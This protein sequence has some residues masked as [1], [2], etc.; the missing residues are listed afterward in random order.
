MM[1]RIIYSDQYS[2]Q[3]A[4]RIRIIEPLQ[5]LDQKETFQCTPLSQISREYLVNGRIQPDNP[6]F[7]DADI[8]YL[9]ITDANHTNIDKMGPIIDY[10][11]KNGKPVVTNLDDL[12]F[13]IPKNV[14]IKQELETSMP[15]FKELVRISRLVLVTGKQL[16]EVSAQINPNVIAI[17]NMIDPKMYPSRPD[18]NEKIHIGW[19][20]LPTHF[21][22]F[23]ITLPAIKELLRNYPDKV[24]FTIFG[25]FISDMK[26]VIT[27]A[28]NLKIGT[29]ELKK[30]F[31]SG[32]FLSDAIRMAQALEDI[33]FR[34][35][36]LV[37]Y[38][39]FPKML[40]KLDFDIG[41]CPLRDNLFNRCK[42]AIKF[43]QYAAVNTVSVASKMYPYSAECNY[44]VENNPEAW[45]RHIEALI[46]DK[47][48]RE[49]LLQE[50]RS[51]IFSN[52]N[53]NSGISIYETIFKK[54]AS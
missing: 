29:Q 30:H 2:N 54:L 39:N 46:L 14:T 10:F 36:P 3:A 44:L 40:S 32:H 45:Y 49:A 38:G 42:S 52:R 34:H 47:S 15:I 51:Y 28:Q 18:N 26:K 22:D 13:N 33:P 21:A 23:S 5:F 1:I 37:E 11:L 41:L 7:R 25:F 19:C 8:L 16:K 4:T 20:G 6:Y 35:V 43:A 9:F 12:Y 48:L 27:D 31:P 50:Q 17:P 53:Y 24:D